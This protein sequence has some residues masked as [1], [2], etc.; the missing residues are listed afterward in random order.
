VLGCDDGLDIV[1]KFEGLLEGCADFF[2]VGGREKILD[3][4]VLGWNVSSDVVGKLEGGA[5]FPVIGGRVESLEALVLRCDVGS[6]V[7]RSFEGLLEG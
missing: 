6:G 3:G 2:M 7:G 5:D 4:L 1:G